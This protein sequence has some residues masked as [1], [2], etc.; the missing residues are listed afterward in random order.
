M[1][2]K[3]NS[4]GQHDNNSGTSEMSASFMYDQV[5]GIVLGRTLDIIS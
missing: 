2:H 3:F 5:K 1:S 4:V